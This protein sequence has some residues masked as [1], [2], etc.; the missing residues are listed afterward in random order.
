MFGQ[1]INVVGRLYRIHTSVN[2]SSIPMDDQLSEVFE[3]RFNGSLILSET[4]HHNGNSSTEKRTIFSYAKI[5][6]PLTCNIRSEK[7]NCDSV[8]FN[9]NKPEEIHVLQKRMEV[10]EEHFEEEKVNINSTKFIK[11]NLDNEI[12]PSFTTPFLEKVKL[13]LIISLAAIAGIIVMCLFGVCLLKSNTTLQPATGNTININNKSTS[14]NETP[15][16]TMVTP[17]CPEVPSLITEAPPATS[18]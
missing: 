3:F 8:K 4:C 16:F 2:A 15:V 12:P 7:I 1:D 13:P 6:L 11:S 9:S 14:S 18:P 10:L 5:K 17:S